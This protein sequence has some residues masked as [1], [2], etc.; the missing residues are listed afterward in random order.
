[1]D[2]WNMEEIDNGTLLGWVNGEPFRLEQY[3]APAI[4]S[5]AREVI[6]E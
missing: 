4:L 3:E 2:T 1:M 5:F 6:I